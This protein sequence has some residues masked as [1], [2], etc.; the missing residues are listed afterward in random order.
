MIFINGDIFSI[1]FNQIGD[2][3][4]SFYIERQLIEFNIKDNAGVYEYAVIPQPMPKLEDDEKTFDKH[5]WIPLIFFLLILNL[6][7]FLFKKFELLG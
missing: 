1:K 3:S 6:A 2:N 5:F 7:F 4:F